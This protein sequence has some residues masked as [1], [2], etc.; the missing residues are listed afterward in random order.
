MK[1][2]LLLVT[3]LVLSF[4]SLC[5]ASNG[6]QLD[7]EE[8]MAANLIAAMNGAGEYAEVSKDFST[9]LTKNLSAAKFSD[10]QKKVKEQI[11]NIA[12][13]KLLVLQKYDKADRLVYLAKGRKVQNVEVSLVFETAGKKPLINEVSIRPVEIKKQDNAKQVETKK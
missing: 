7:Q 9:G 4:S 13:Q 6:S 5:F 8:K 12:E 2:I 1:K 3:V 11:G 10:L